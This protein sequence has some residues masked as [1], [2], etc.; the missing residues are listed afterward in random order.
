[1]KVKFYLSFATITVLTKNIINLKIFVYSYYSLTK[2]LEFFST[3]TNFITKFLKNHKKT[4][5]FVAFLS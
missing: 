3:I 5:N 4:K 1:M 2:N